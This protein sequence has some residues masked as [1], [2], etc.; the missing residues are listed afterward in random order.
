[1]IM[2]RKREISGMIFISLRLFYNES[3]SLENDA[4]LTTQGISAPCLALLVRPFDCSG[5]EALPGGFN[6]IPEL[7]HRNEDISGFL[8]VQYISI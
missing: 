1:M 8:P 2:Q 6:R 5:G 4:L 3:V 7:I